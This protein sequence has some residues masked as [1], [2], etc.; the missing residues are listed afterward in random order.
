M[1][2]PVRG[3]VLGKFMPP[4][5][6]H[7]FIC[8]T[9]IRM[10]DIMTVLVCSTDDEPLPG[11]L[12]HQWM[13]E[14]LP[15]AS[16]LHLH[17]NLPQTKQDHP[18]FWQLWKNAIRENHPQPI[19]YIFGSE[20]YVFQLADVLGAKPV[21]V[22]PAREIFPVSGSK[23]RDCPAN[24]GAY[25]PEQVR[26]F[27]NKRICL[28]GPE[29]AGK[30]VLTVKLANRY[31]TKYMPEYGRIYDQS[32]KQ[33]KPGPR[34]WVSGELLDLART[35]IAM[36]QSLMRHANRVLFEDTDPLQTAIW[37][38][39]LVGT[40][41]NGMRLL[42]EDYDAADFYIILTPSVPFINDG[43]RYFESQATREEFYS[44]AVDLVQA[45]G[46]PFVTVTDK[47]WQAR[48]EL[49]MQKV[50]DFLGF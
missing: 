28:L 41:S 9:G 17:R 30:S 29:S 47:D 18:D 13:T 2:E 49:T 3:F 14:C 35:H 10:S 45:R 20:D 50:K 27:Y 12:R 33:T 15:Q 5:L 19:E 26:V 44:E 25:L 24:Y 40:T 7:I 34:K 46:V 4:H 16:V 31:Q 39:H 32:Y 8:E 23:V 11:K 22:D 6:G 38:K 21:L 43:G 48:E 1:P 42:L 36:S 37:E